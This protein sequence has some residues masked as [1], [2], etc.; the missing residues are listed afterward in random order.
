MQVNSENNE[1]TKKR[2]GE[3]KKIFQ[4]TPHI[5]TI[6]KMFLDYDANLLYVSSV[7]KG[8]RNKCQ[9][10]IIGTIAKCNP[11]TGK[12]ERD[13][14]YCSI[15]QEATQ[16]SALLVERHRVIAGFPSG[17]LSV[18]NNIHQRDMSITSFRPVHFCPIV[19]LEIIRRGHV[20]VSG[21]VD[22]QINLFAFYQ[23]KRIGTIIFPKNSKTDAITAFASDKASRLVIGTSKGLVYLVDFTT[24]D[25][26]SFEPQEFELGVPVF[27]ADSSIKKIHFDLLTNS[28]IPIYE[29]MTKVLI[30]SLGNKLVIELHPFISKSIIPQITI[31][32]FE[33]NIEH[34]THKDQLILM[35]GNTLG[36][37]QI[38]IINHALFKTS[39][40]SNEKV[41]MKSIKTI[42]AHSSAITHIKFDAFKIVTVSKSKE[43]KV[44]DTISGALYK[45]LVIKNMRRS[46]L[47]VNQS[48]IINI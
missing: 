13:F 36:K 20:L 1:I 31:I 45:N 47:N 40:L 38:Y 21:D 33:K 26:S 17:A 42:H 10:I 19:V 16:L 3:R 7:S 12:V 46:L 29:T 14:I 27:T 43:L 28:I 44:F 9:T 22:G 35:T 18:I 4:F 11:S 48:Q 34:H 32:Q 8:N 6:D 41:E 15:D 25:E 5:G 37:I 30:I 24:L 23:M 39:D 2:L